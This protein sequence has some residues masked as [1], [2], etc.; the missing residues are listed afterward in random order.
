MAICRRSVG[1]FWSFPD[2]KCQV[3]SKCN[4]KLTVATYCSTTLYDHILMNCV[5]RFL[6]GQGCVNRHLALLTIFIAKASKERTVAAEVWNVY[7]MNVVTHLYKWKVIE[8][9]KRNQEERQIKRSIRTE[10]ET[11]T[12]LIPMGHRSVGRW[13]QVGHLTA[14]WVVSRWAGE[15]AATGVCAVCQVTGATDGS[16]C[17]SNMVTVLY[18]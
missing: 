11:V 4:W 10:R 18:Y 6:S 17:L 9:K 1:Y 8:R 5:C 3:W 2:V 16:L 12:C 14:D 7:F 13:T 15:V